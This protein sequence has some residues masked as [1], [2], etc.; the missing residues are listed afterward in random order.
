MTDS[1]SIVKDPQSVVDYSINWAAVLNATS[2]VDTISSSTWAADNS[3]IVDS[4]SNT[5]S[6]SSVWVSAGRVGRYSKLTNTIV[7]TLGRTHER[8]ITVELKPR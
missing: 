1:F 3:L 8:T 5:T 7:T 6:A 4:D 2:P